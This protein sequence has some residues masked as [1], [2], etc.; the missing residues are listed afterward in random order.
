MFCRNKNTITMKT[1]RNALGELHRDDD[2]P[3]VVYK[4][5]GLGN[6]SVWYQNGIIARADDQPHKV[7]YD[8]SCAW[9]IPKP[10]NHIYTMCDLD[11]DLSKLEELCYVFHRDGKKPA[12][13]LADGTQIWFNRGKIE[14]YYLNGVYM[15]AV[16]LADGTKMWFW[17]NMQI[18]PQ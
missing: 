8:G 15:P 5:K 17:N 11:I 6:T 14:G 4:H 16:I 7:H 3:A 12:V 2:Y 18:S 1:W 13:I 10:S 9:M